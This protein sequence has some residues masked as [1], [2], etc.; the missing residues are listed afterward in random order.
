MFFRRSPGSSFCNPAAGHQFG[1]WQEPGE[2]EAWVTLVRT[3]APGSVILA[4]QGVDGWQVRGAA[5]T[6]AAAVSAV[7]C[8]PSPGLHAHEILSALTMNMAISVSASQD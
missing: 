3:P 1:S 8:G 5:D 4:M 6:G 7:R 2:P